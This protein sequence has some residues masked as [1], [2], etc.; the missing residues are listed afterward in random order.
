M[1]QSNFM[2]KNLIQRMVG[3][4]DLS[5]AS[6]ICPI[7]G[8]FET[9]VR[10]G[11]QPFCPECFLAEQRLSDD[12]E[13]LAS[14]SNHGLMTFWNAGA[15]QN[16]VPLRFLDATFENYRIEGSEMQQTDQMRFCNAMMDFAD[17]FQRGARDGRNIILSGRV[18]TGKTHLAI[19]MARRMAENGFRAAY[20]TVFDLM[21]PA[22]RGV[23][24]AQTIIERLN[25]YDLVILD[26]I[27][28]HPDF[29]FSVDLM[30]SKF[31]QLID[32]RYM[33]CLATV[34]VTNVSIGDLETSRGGIG[35]RAM[36]RMK[37]AVIYKFF[38]ESAR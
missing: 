30:A 17:N 14:L 34:L 23:D 6:G 22:Q 4:H 10:P 27:G 19:A 32:S 7:H 2:G 26:E 28:A 35:E 25:T 31:F 37:D 38:W 24:D 1:S 36:D 13:N 15:I 8:N 21:R 12:E 16:E 5:A 11:K 33:N 3:V 20:L 29:G 9:L 18:G